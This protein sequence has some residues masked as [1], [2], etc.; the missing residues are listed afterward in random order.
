MDHLLPRGVETTTMT[1]TILNARVALLEDPATGLHQTQ[2]ATLLEHLLRFH[3]PAGET[4]RPI[5]VIPMIV[6]RVVRL[7]H[8]QETPTP[9]IVTAATPIDLVDLLMPP[10]L[11]V[12]P[13]DSHHRPLAQAP[14]TVP[15]N[16][17]LISPPQ[18]DSIC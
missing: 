14:P 3:H 15:V 1:P 8:S 4:T 11:K 12:P 6:T 16:R 17:N 9:P 18:V 5:R 2:V 10:V 13:I 7:L